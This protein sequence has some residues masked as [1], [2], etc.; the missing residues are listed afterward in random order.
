MTTF[1]EAAG[2]QT[3]EQAAASIRLFRGEEQGVSTIQPGGYL[4]G[5]TQELLLS[6]AGADALLQLDYTGRT[7]RTTRGG[8][9]KR[10]KRQRGAGATMGYEK[11]VHSRFESRRRQEIQGYAVQAGNSS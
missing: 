6:A 3:M 2:V 9:I 1:W 8:G 4:D 11:S 5:P 10:E 7:C